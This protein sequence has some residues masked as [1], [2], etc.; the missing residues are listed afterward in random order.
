MIEDTPGPDATAELAHETLIRSWSRLARWVDS[1]AGFQRWLVTMEDRAA[2]NELLPEAR[3]SEAERWLV[4]RPD[5]IPAEVHEL[6]GRSRDLLLQRIAELEEARNRAEKAAHQAEEARHQVEGAA[7]QRTRRQRQF[8]AALT[9]LLVV[10]VGGFLFAFQQR[11]TAQIQR[12][13]AIFNQITA[14]ADRL[15]STDVSLAAQLDLTAYRMRPTPDLYTALITLGN[16]ALSTPLTGHT[17]A[18]NAV[19]FSPD[20]HTLA[21]GSGDRTV[22][23]W[24]VADPT[25]P[26]PLGPPLT[27]HTNA[28]RSVA[29]S[30]DGHTLATGS[31]DR[32]VRL[33][34]V[35]DP[36]HPT[37]LGPPLTGHTN[38]VV[39]VAFS[40]DGHTL[41]TGSFDNTVRLWNIPS[42]L[43][44]GHTSA[45][46]SVAFSPD[47][48][49]LATGS[50]DR[51][52]RL[53]NVTDPTHPTSLGPPL[54]GHTSYVTAVAFSPD[55]HTLATGSS[56]QT[57]RLWNVTDPT[58]PAPLG[59]SLTGHTNTVFSVAFSPDGHTLATGGDDT[60]WLWGMNV[61]RAIQRICATTTNTLT[62]TTWKQ[63]VS[64][65]LPYRPPCP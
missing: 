63:N 20:G 51:T 45:V 50:D 12:D 26:T 55:G 23:L 52:V 4:E 56:D 35:T 48:H 43:M 33:W 46:G 3:I 31:E 18:V 2:E 25:H 39:S 34:D 9:A 32:T 28:V 42:T 47:G 16:T 24:N 11:H 44:I 10:A 14:Q 13:T 53:W 61:D 29:F 40:P 62:P 37:S 8:V 58:H 17:K 65:D 54:T 19:A 49:T 7:R 41:A 59:Q 38:A 64:P 57:V 36:T 30:P 27:G 1:D 21:T 22:R 60:A 5:D 6:V 15:R